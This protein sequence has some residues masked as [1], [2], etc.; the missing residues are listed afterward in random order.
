MIFFQKKF[1]RG[2]A[3]ACLCGL[4][5]GSFSVTSFSAQAA[6]A[7]MAPK[8][9]QVSNAK[10]IG[11]DDI[12]LLLNKAYKAAHIQNYTGTLIAY[13]Q[14]E[15]YSSRIEHFSSHGN[16]YEERETLDGP[17]RTFL[18]DNDDVYNVVPNQQTTVENREGRHRF[19]AFLGPSENLNH[20]VPKWIATERVAGVETTLVELQPKDNLRFTYRLSIDNATSLLLRLQI[21]EKGHLIEQIGFTEIHFDKHPAQQKIISDIQ[22]LKKKKLVR[23]KDV[24][25]DPTIYG[26]SF[27]PAVLGFEKIHAVQRMM[28]VGDKGG[29]V[30]VQQFVYSDGITHVSAFVTPTVS[31]AKPKENLVATPKNN[32]TH[33]FNK[34]YGQFVLSLVGEVPQRTLEKMAEQIIYK[35]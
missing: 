11:Q 1:Y 31:N 14:D 30:K 19:P 28:P 13:S 6:Q 33:T 20:Y 18:R 27:R 5:L 22:E 34:I 8:F 7:Q 25:A 12:Y 9:V 10:K 23:L 35:P 15:F 2:N 32:A 17:L 29:L 24:V 21:L 3:L 26:S 16:I 4:V